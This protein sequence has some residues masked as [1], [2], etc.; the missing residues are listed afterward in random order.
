MYAQNVSAGI[1][2]K[3]MQSTDTAIVAKVASY[4]SVD[5]MRENARTAGDVITVVIAVAQAFAVTD[6]SAPSAAIVVAAAFVTM[7][8]NVPCAASA[9]V[10]VYAI[11]IGSVSSAGIATPSAR[12]GIV[13]THESV[14]QL[15]RLRERV[16]QLRRSSD[17]P[18]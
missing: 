6:E 5:V 11:T 14:M 7:G 3:V 18:N 17:A 9:M 13:L 1:P 16:A 8:D 2:P 15:E 10:Q 4:V 12:Y